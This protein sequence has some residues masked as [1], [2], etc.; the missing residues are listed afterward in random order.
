MELDTTAML[1]RFSTSRWSATKMDK[2]ITKDVAE[3]Y[4]ADE[5]M[6]RYTKYLLP[7]DGD[8]SYKDIS[9]A[10]SAGRKAFY[11]ETLPWLDNGARILTA[12]NFMPLGQRMR[13]SKSAWEGL[14]PIFYQA[15]PF[16]K[17]RARTQLKTAYIEADYPPQSELPEYFTWE[18]KF[19]PIP[20][21]VD[22][23]VTTL[24]ADV[25]AEIKHQIGADVECA[26]MKAME[27]PYKQLFDGVAHMASRLIGAKECVCSNCKGKKFTSG[28]FKDSLVDNL[29]TL[30][31]RLPRLNLTGDQT[32]NACIAQVKSSLTEFQPDLI[33]DNEHIRKSLAE[34]AAAIQQNLVGY[35]SQVA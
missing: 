34:R 29:L 11:E 21:A 22:F 13:E 28:E 27:E 8:K 35:M 33:R 5:K 24:N 1:A 2:K 6:G 10:E 14:L 19:F 17:A 7:R 31:D 20:D 30:C 3:Q 4:Q 16:L 18:L 12:A 23:R 32:L 25:V 9:A 15:Y 26:V